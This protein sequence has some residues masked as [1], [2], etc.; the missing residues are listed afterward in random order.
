MADDTEII[1]QEVI[2]EPTET[3]EKIKAENARIA[4]ALSKANKEAEHSRKKAAALEAEKTAKEQAEM[5]ELERLRAELEAERAKVAQAE[6]RKRQSDIRRAFVDEASKQGAAYPDDVYRLA[7]LSGVDVDEDGKVAGVAE[8]VKALVE[9]GRIPM[10]GKAPAPNL[11]GGAGGGDRSK[12]KVTLTTDELEIARKMNI[13][14]EK[15]AANK[16]AISVQQRE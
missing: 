10:S 5:T 1:E 9:S 15:Y 16:A 2:E 13:T 6:E 7:D 8:A 14:P 4:A 11:D 12:A 3:L